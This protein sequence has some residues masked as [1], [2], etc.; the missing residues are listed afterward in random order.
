MKPEFKKGDKVWV[1]DTSDKVF[2]AIVTKVEFYSHEYD[3]A[4]IAWVDPVDYRIVAC[5]RP[6]SYNFLFRSERAARSYESKNKG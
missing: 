1:Y 4:D 3:K 5:C 2:E 6:T